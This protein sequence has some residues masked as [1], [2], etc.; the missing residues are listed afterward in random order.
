[1]AFD[2]R[3]WGVI[4]P[5]G[6]QEFLQDG[7]VIG[8]PGIY[9][10]QSR[11]ETLLDLS[12]VNYFAE[13]GN[14]LFVDDLLYL[15]ASDTVGFYRVLAVDFETGNLIIGAEDAGGDVHG[16]GSSTDNAIVRWN[17]TDGEFIQNSGVIVDDSN[18]VTGVNQLTVG[19]VSVFSNVI[20]VLDRHTIRQYLT[21]AAS[22]HVAWQPPATIT[23][24]QSYSWPDALPLANGY[25][26]TANTDGTTSWEDPGVNGLIWNVVTGAAETIVAGNGYFVQSGALTTFTL[27][28]TATIGDTFEIR[29]R[30]NTGS[31]FRLFEPGAG[32]KLQFSGAIVGP[33]GGEM[34][35]STSD[36]DGFT[37][38]YLGPSGAETGKL[39][40]AKDIVGNFDVS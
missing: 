19:N 7:S 27:P 37:C 28:A 18:N 36:S 10:Y 9:T 30:I 5:G 38:V 25:V 3:N 17:G 33:P 4:Q 16:P 21:D 11:D 2:F 31:S 8:A 32:F 15:A 23:Q 22:L 26:F 12:A 39:W 29:G 1:M 40:I 13:V 24:T 20:R 34:V 35:I 14:T 6:T